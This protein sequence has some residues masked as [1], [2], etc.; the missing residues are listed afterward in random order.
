M[1]PTLVILFLMA[2]SPVQAFEEGGTVVLES[3]DALAFEIDNTEGE[4]LWIEYEVFVLQGP[5]VNVWFVDQEGHDDFF[6]R[7]VGTFSYYPAHTQKETTY[8]NESFSWDNSDVF[9][10]IID[11][12]NNDAIGQNATVEYTIVWETYEF[13]EFYMV[14][15]MVLMIV[16]IIVVVVALV[17][18]MAVRKAQAEA[19]QR[20]AEAAKEASDAWDDEESDRPQP[21]EPY[22]EWVV[23]SS[24]RELAMD[25]AT[26]WDPSQDEP[27]DRF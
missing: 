17:A 15:F 11:N 19:D 16:V 22:P 13:G 27:E 25:D 5:P 1:V 9:Y 7:E 18:L 24:M 12:V 10:V 4:D 20:Q 6:D 26:G 3:G 14:M 8:A 21:P 2:S 23:E